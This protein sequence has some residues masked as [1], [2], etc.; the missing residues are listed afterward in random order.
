MWRNTLTCG[1]SSVKCS[2]MWFWLVFS[3]VYLPIQ[4]VQIN[5][6]SQQ[7]NNNLKMVKHQ[8]TAYTIP[9]M[10]WGKKLKYFWALATSEDHPVL[11]P[12]S[13]AHLLAFVVNIWRSFWLSPVSLSLILLRPLN[14]PW[15]QYSKVPIECWGLMPSAGG[16][17]SRNSSNMNWTRPKI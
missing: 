16:V 11:D 9:G 7:L 5:F 13:K 1:D 8:V 2:T 6:T 12:S 10:I 14:S 4:D 15:S 17:W 3:F